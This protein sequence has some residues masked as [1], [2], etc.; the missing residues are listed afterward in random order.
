MEEEAFGDSHV[1][2]SSGGA[3]ASGEPNAR[4]PSRPERLKGV[5]WGQ[6]RPLSVPIQGGSER[7]VVTQFEFLGIFLPQYP[8]GLHG[9]L[10]AGS[11]K[12]SPWVW[13]SWRPLYHNIRAPRA[14]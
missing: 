6:V 13:Y 1:V 9:D 8:L 11:L 12:L 2:V 4:P 3:G 5:Y 7:G 10:N 14:V